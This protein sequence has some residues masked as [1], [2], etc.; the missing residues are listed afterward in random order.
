MS[1]IEQCARFHIM[2]AHRLCDQTSEIFD[3]KINEDTLKQCFQSLRQYYE[4]TRAAA[5]TSGS[6]PAVLKPSANEAEFRAY[7]ILVNLTESSILSEIQR[8]PKSIRHDK[9]V[10]FALKVYFAFN[11]KNYIH[12]FRLVSSPECDYLQA[13]ILHR[14]F[15]NF[16]TLR[17]SIGFSLIIFFQVLLSNAVF[18]F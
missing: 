8:W 16:V 13:C 6:A 7:V 1:I 9:Q 15:F 10:R 12:F 5:S 3:V 18:G 4:A 11:S 17:L 2:C 14:Y